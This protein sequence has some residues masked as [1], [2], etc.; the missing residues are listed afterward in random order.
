MMRGR[1]ID[2]ERECVLIYFLGVWKDDV[3]AFSKLY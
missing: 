2:K 1:E 3:T